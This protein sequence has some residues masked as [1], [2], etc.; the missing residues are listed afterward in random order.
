MDPKACEIGGR[1]FFLWLNKFQTES[2]IVEETS[3]AAVEI[4]FVFVEFS[5]DR[6]AS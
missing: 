4:T 5:N 1:G 3:W 6:V 2:W